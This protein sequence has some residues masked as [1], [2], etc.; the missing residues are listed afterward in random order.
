M[1]VK[2]G[3]QH[4]PR[5]IVL[6]SGQSAEEVERAVAD[7]LTGKTALLSLTDEHG[8]KVLIPADRLAYIDIGESAVRKV[9][10]SAL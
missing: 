3:V 4:A 1:E 8:R 10:F 5:E 9:G 7:A 2:I 6:E